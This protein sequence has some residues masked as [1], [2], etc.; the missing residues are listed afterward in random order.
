MPTP[1]SLTPLSSYA[2]AASRAPALRARLHAQQALRAANF[3]RVLFKLRSRSTKRKASPARVPSSNDDVRVHDAALERATAE[4]M[5]AGAKRAKKESNAGDVARHSDPANAASAAET[6]SSPQQPLA[7]DSAQETHRMHTTVAAEQVVARIKEIRQTAMTFAKNQPHLRFQASGGSFMQFR[8]QFEAFLEQLQ[9]EHV[10]SCKPADAVPGVPAELH[11]AQQSNVYYMLTIAAPKEAQAGLRSACERT[12]YDAWKLLRD[13]F[14]GEEAAYK[15]QLMLQ[16]ASLRWLPKEPFTAFDAR[17][18]SLIAELELITGEEKSPEDKQAAILRAI[19]TREGP[20][21]ATDYMRMRNVSNALTFAAVGAGRSV[22]FETW[23]SHMR[24]EARAIEEQE[25]THHDSHRHHHGGAHDNSAL[26]AQLNTVTMSNGK[27]QPCR[28]WQRSNGQSCRYGDSCRFAHGAVQQG[29]GPHSASQPASKLPCRDWR[30]GRCNRGDS[31]RYAHG[32]ID[33]SSQRTEAQTHMHAHSVQQQTIA[34][35]SEEPVPLGDRQHLQLLV[36]AQGQSSNPP[37]VSQHMCIIDSGAGGS[38]TPRREL[39][40]QL[41]P[42][43]A[44]VWLTGALSGQIVCANLGG[45]AVIPLGSFDL[46]LDHVVLC[47]QLQHTLLSM[48]QL[49]K[50]GYTITL[51]D[52]AGELVDPSGLHRVPL[53]YTGN[54]TS[55]VVEWSVDTQPS[56]ADSAL[57]PANA[58]TRSQ[59]AQLHQAEQPPAST[60]SS[61]SSAGQLQTA[62]EQAAPPV[63]Q[64]VSVQP[65]DTSPAVST[66]VVLAHAR[67]GHLGERKLQQVVQHAAVGSFLLSAR[68]L[69]GVQALVSKCDPCQ[70][71]KQARRPFGDAIDHQVTAANDMATADL[72]GPIT[73]RASSSDASPVKVYSS[74]IVDV[75]TRHPDVWLLQSKR[76]ASDHV[77]SYFHRANALTGQQLKRMHT[78]GGREYNKA[79]HALT[80]RGTNHTRTPVSTSNWNAIVERKH[81][82]LLDMATALLQHALYVPGS[83]SSVALNRIIDV[84]LL[85]EVLATAVLLHAQLTVP[86]GQTATQYELWSK[87]R[88]DAGWLRVWGCDAM[89][90]IP[91]AD[92]HGRLNARAEPAIFIG[93]DRR[94]HHCWRFLCSGDRIVVSRDAT[95]K[96][97]SFAQLRARVAAAIASAAAPADGSNSSSLQAD[98]ESGSDSDSE[99]EQE[100]QQVDRRTAR[101]IA[102]AERREQLALPAADSPAA[103]GT[104]SARVTRTRTAA[105][106]TGVNLDDFGMALAVQLEGTSGAQPEPSSKQIHRSSVSIPQSAKEA[107]SSPYAAQWQAAMQ[108]EL[109][110]LRSHSVYEEVERPQNV[111][112]VGCRWVFAVKCDTN[113]IV[114]K[115]KARLTARGFSQQHGVDYFHTFSAVVQYRSLRLLLALAAQR[116]MKLELMDVVTAYLHADLPETVYMQLPE[117]ISSSENNGRN[118][119]QARVWR[120]RKALYGLKQAGREWGKLLRS[121]LLEQSFTQLRS[122]SCVYVKRAASGGLMLVSTYVDDIPSAVDASAAAEWGDIKRHFE[123]RFDIKFLGDAEWLLNMRIARCPSSGSITLDQQAYTEQL[124]ANVGGFEQCRTVSTPSAQEELSS[125]MAPSSA[126]ERRTMATVPYR[127]VVGAL[128]YLAHSTRPDIAHAVQQVSQYSQDPGAKHWAAVKQILRYL[129]GTCALGLRFAASSSGSAGQLSQPLVSYVDASHGTCA[130]SMRST[131]GW[132]LGLGEGNWIDWCTRKQTVVALSSCEAEYMALAAAAQGVLWARQFMEEVARVAQQPQQLTDSAARPSTLLMQGDNKSAIAMAVNN[133][134]HAGSRHIRLRYHFIREQV[135][136][137]SLTLQWVPTGRQLADVLT[138]PLHGQA[139]RQWRDR[140]VAPPAS[141]SSSSSSSGSLSSEAPQH[142]PGAE[143]QQVTQQHAQ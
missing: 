37:G 5:G 86:K 113:N 22:P 67:Y 28:L 92:R 81:R 122:D 104:G 12:A 136:D 105:R 18:T 29:A 46:R 107:L 14:L 114:E 21:S 35:S 6:N 80:A 2:A 133:S 119:L 94:H 73:V 24:D 97:D 42:L 123:R 139:F 124:L 70:L 8:M 1:P 103:S 47:E 10:L 141:S 43:D 26:P 64:A 83:G 77:I 99:P 60:T 23:L 76:E 126:E 3:Q 131:T 101:L 63:P 56:Q 16:F 20:H 102:A 127:T 44:P 66:S 115:F 51:G 55:L 61:E 90:H 17:F 117:G 118:R 96:E 79:Q 84:L 4:E 9:C 121:F 36:N 140:L 32:A 48:V 68:D 137:G 15:Q 59:R 111:N 87:Q 85:R 52:E 98:Q 50:L 41:Q 72:C 71:A 65:D 125:S 13:R 53:S 19:Q 116:G 142:P 130:D 143:E 39:F 106:Q 57:L 49:R 110:S 138:K 93:Y 82:S 30:M 31:C 120:L 128:N 75:F 54:V 91:D 34:G 132:V 100:G 134:A 11:A 58:M 62:R 135:E 88:P 108:K 89:V 40:E 27:Q 33:A 25:R 38:M 112:V 78:D 45:A 129:A 74:V 69:V 95:F 7:S 109:A